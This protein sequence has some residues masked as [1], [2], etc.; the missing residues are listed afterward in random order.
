VTVKDLKAGTESTTH[1]RFVFIGAGGAALKLLQMSGIPEAKDYAGFPVGGQFL[2]FQNPD[3][4]SR[5]GVKAYGMAE[6]GSPPMSVP[7]L[8]T[9]ASWTASRWSCSGRSR[10]TAPSSSSTARGGTCIP[11]S[12]TTT[13]ARCW[14]WARTTWTWCST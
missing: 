3:V 13:S 12:P 7:H 2:A 8:D 11:R 14:E 9:R 10:C 4:T 5:H 1:A 6:T